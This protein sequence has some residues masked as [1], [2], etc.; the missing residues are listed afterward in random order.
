MRED[1]N[2]LNTS[3]VKIK[4]KRLE[5]KMVYREYMLMK[6]QKKE[7]T[8]DAFKNDQMKS[9][10]DTEQILKK[11]RKEKK[12]NSEFQKPIQGGLFDDLKI[13]VDQFGIDFDQS[14]TK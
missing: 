4:V 12:L 7:N 2:S 14:N 11:T 6:L 5:R 3:M 8:I 10:E 13:L 9:S 1:A